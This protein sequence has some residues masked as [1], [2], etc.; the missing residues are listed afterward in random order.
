MHAGLIRQPSPSELH[1]LDAEDIDR[2]DQRL[3]VGRAGLFA[4]R[5]EVLGS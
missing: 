1:R 2:R 5:D 3:E 4:V